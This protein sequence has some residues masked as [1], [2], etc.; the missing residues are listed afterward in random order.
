M[1]DRGMAKLCLPLA[2]RAMSMRILPRLWQASLI[3]FNPCFW[4]N[5]H[6][7]NFWQKL[8]KPF[9]ILA[10]MENVTDFVFREIVATTCPPDVLFT[11]FTNV[12]G[13]LSLGRKNLISKFKFSENQRPI[14]AQIWGTKPESFYK[15]A[16]MVRELGFDG[17]DINMGCPDKTVLKNGSG[18]ALSNNPKLA[19]EIIEAT[20]KGAKDIPVSVKTRL[21]VREVKTEEWI[22]FLLEQKIDTL[23]IH[24]R[25]AHQMSEGLAD[26]NE[27][28][29]A[30]GIRNKIAPDTLIVGNGDVKSYAEAVEKSQKYGP[31]GIM[32]ARGIFANPWVFEPLRPLRHAQG[33]VRSGLRPPQHS[34]GEYVQLLL[35]HL[36]LYE[37]TWGGTRDFNIMKK[38]FK[39]Y[40]NN[41][42]GS[43]KLRAKLM[44]TN[45]YQE[46]REIL[47]V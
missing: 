9:T 45:N 14:V 7:S 42:P 5:P 11:E 47:A 31:D 27:I 28:G 29:K 25:T 2:D 41:F 30:V 35:K 20:K 44:N 8:P 16:K 3:I 12:E 24:G 13:L 15:V 39:M 4:Y 19:G 36:D 43:A 6:M 37:K 32:I 46:V 17:V 18:A 40:I 21:G 23:T 22:T 26:W 38:F 10:P 34:R 33:D 1:S